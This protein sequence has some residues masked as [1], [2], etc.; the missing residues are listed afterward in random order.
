[1]TIAPQKLT[2]PCILDENILSVIKSL[3]AQIVP[4]FVETKKIEVK[5]KKYRPP[6]KWD[7]KSNTSKPPSQS[8]SQSQS[9]S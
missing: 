6:E 7:E 4:I 2:T 3:D 1:L 9:Q 8:Q 5:K